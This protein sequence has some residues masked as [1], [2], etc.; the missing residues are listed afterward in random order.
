MENAEM[1]KELVKLRTGQEPQIN[2]PTC[3]IWQAEHK[4][5]I[6]CS[7]NLS[8]GMMSSVMMVVLKSMLYE[9]KDFDDFL[10]TQDYVSKMTNKIL[11]AKTVE[12]LKAIE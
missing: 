7:S 3:V 2:E 4:D 5:C 6:G 10:K 12:E 11:N 9:P 1:V 8:C